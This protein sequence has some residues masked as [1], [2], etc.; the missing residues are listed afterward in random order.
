MQVVADD[1][2]LLPHLAR[3]ASV[4]MTPEKVE[5]LLAFPEVDHTGLVRVQGKTELSQDSGRPLIGL[6]G[7][8]PGRA[9]HDEVSGRGE[10]HPPALAEPDVSLSTHPAPIIQ[11]HGTSPSRQWAKRTPARAATVC[12]HLRARSA[13]RCSRLYFCMAQRTR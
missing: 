4:K 13:C 12:S 11:P 10:S 5:A 8:L 6:L 2:P 7:L 1:V 9:Q 3:H